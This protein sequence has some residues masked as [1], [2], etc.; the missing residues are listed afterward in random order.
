MLWKVNWRLSVCTLTVF[1]VFGLWWCFETK[2]VNGISRFLSLCILQTRDLKFLPFVLFV[3]EF[4]W[5]Y[6]VWM[7][8]VYFLK[9]QMILRCD[10]V[11]LYC[12]LDGLDEWLRCFIQKRW[13]ISDF[14]L[15]CNFCILDTEN[16]WLYS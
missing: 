9:M 10:T 11:F 5:I 13:D 3:A 2:L 7:S 14:Y 1:D 4:P 15:F 6:I 16:D 8:K 12:S